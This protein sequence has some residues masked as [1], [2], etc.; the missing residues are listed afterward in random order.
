VQAIGVR[1]AHLSPGRIRLKVDDLKHDE[2]RARDIEAQLRSV[3][4]IHSAA[5]NPITGSLV[6]DYD[7]AAMESMEL[8]FSVA[9]ILGIS[10][11]DLDPDELRR[12]MSHHGN[13]AKPMDGAIADGLESAVKDLNA[14]LTRTIGADLGIVL[15]LLL[16]GL[17]LRSLMVSEKTV[18]PSWYDY[19]WFAFGTYFALNRPSPAPL[20]LGAEHRTEGLH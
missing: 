15:P 9:R 3:S 11:N 7:E 2:R 5:A 13:G 14:A 20:P 6:L 1:L 8:P 4:G 16:A 10:L 18:L 19:L 17:G 12:L